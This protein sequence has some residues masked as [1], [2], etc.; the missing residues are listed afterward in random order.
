MLSSAGK[1]SLL[2]ERYSEMIERVNS[3]SYAN[4]KYNRWFKD[5]IHGWSV[6]KKFLKEVSGLRSLILVVL[7]FKPD[8]VKDLIGDRWL[9]GVPE[10][11]IACGGILLR[12]HL[13]NLRDSM[14]SRG[15][16]LRYIGYTM[17]FQKSGMPHFNTIYYGHF[18]LDID[19]IHR[20]W[21][22][23]ERQG[24]DVKKMA[25][26]AAAT[27]CTK[28]IS[29][30]NDMEKVMDRELCKRLKMVMFLYKTRQFNLRRRRGGKVSEDARSA[31]FIVR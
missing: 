18:L 6:R 7:T 21:P 3:G 17:E 5:N 14:R 28:Y 19:E 13:Q 30:F 29:K 15:R 16:P 31:S 4:N 9:L 2:K 10:W 22:W 27:Y 26:K 11:L 8:Y 24:V 1:L 20:H 25:S 23:S 12:R